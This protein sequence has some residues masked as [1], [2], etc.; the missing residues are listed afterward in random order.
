LDEV[1]SG[2]IQFESDA[3]GTGGRTASGSRSTTSRS[4]HWAAQGAVA[5]VD[6]ALFAGTNFVVSVFLARHLPP[7]GYGAFALAQAVFV[8]ASSGYAAL[9]SEPMT[10]FGAGR[11]A[12]RFGSYLAVLI[13][14]NL[15]VAVVV[16]VAATLAGVLCRTFTAPEL[17]Q[18]FL[19]LAVAGPLLLPAFLGR[20]ANYSRLRP[21]GSLAGGVLYSAGALA[22][23]LLLRAHS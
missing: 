12:D 8:L 18:A 15:A 3:V 9:L 1:S 16:S 23:L 11:Y 13:G 22:T 4:A 20:A 2:G 21:V 5:I 14:G 19:G 10:V 7:T 17:G 6:Q